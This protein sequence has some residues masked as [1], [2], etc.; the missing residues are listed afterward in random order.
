VLADSTKRTKLN[1]PAKP[2]VGVGR[3]VRCAYFFL[4]FDEPSAVAADRW[5]A[6]SLA[7]RSL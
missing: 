2:R 7:S 6:R 3:A 5:A 1:S 4:G